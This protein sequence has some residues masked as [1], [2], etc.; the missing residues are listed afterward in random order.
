M[1]EALGESVKFAVILDRDFRPA[2]EIASVSKKL[3]KRVALTHIHQRKEVENYLLVPGALDRTIREALAER[4]RKGGSPVDSPESTEILLLKVTEKIK[5]EIQ[6]QYTARQIDYQ[7]TLGAKIDNARISSETAAWFE[8]AWATLDTRLSIVP[9]KRVL[10][11]LNEYL[12]KHYKVTVTTRMIIAEMRR[13][14]IPDELT[15]LLRKLDRM[16]S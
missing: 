1:T 16:R 14:E 3:S 8:R 12:Q 15:G 4:E 2:D 5:H 11:L 9:G 10:S 7:R 6:G 13:R